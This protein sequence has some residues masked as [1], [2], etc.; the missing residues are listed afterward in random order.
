MQPRLSIVIPAYNE[1]KRIGATLDSIAAF[2]EHAGHAI[3]VIVVVNNTTD[4]T[5]AVVEGYQKDMPYLRAIDCGTHV[6][7][8]MTKGLAV[9]A[10]MLLAEGEYILYMDA[11]SATNISQIEIF[12]KHF[13]KGYDVVFGSRYIKGAH[14][15]RVWYRDVM[16]KASNLLVQALLLPGIKDTQCGFKCFT[17]ASAKDIF[18]DVQTIG[19][20]FDM[21]VLAIARK[22]G[23]KLREVPVAWHEVG[24]SSVKAG[25]F[26]TSL[27]ELL[28]IRKRV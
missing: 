12:W 25:A 15:H 13:A 20:G 28:E 16:G 18:K 11:D 27:K 2:A 17:Q 23:Y 5:M 6:S 4:D 14:T 10:G 26:I 22:R 9:K 1:A 21:E 8:S 3:E 7:A 19:W 24:H